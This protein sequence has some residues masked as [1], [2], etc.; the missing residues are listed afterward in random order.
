TTTTYAYYATFAVG[1]CK[2][3]I[4]GIG[5]VWVG[6]Q[7]IYDG[8]S[9]LPG[10]IVAGATGGKFSLY[11][12]T[13]TQL[14]DPSIQA[15]RG[16]ANTPAYRGLAYLVFQDFPLKDYGNSLM[17]AQ[18]KAEVIMDGG[19]THVF[20]SQ[21]TVPS[22][23][24]TG[25]PQD[26]WDVATAG[27]YAYVVNSWSNTLQIF[28]VANPA[29]PVLTSTTPTGT[30][31]AG[32]VAVSG[33]Y[34]YVLDMHPLLRIYD[35]TNP[36]APALVS[37]VTLTANGNEYDIVIAGKYAYIANYPSSY[38]LLYGILIY[39][40]SSPAAPARVGLGGYGITYNRL[41][42][43]GNYLYA[44]TP[45]SLLDIYDVSDPTAPVLMS[46]T[47]ITVNSIASWDV[48][49][50]GNYALVTNNQLGLAIYD[51]TNPAA[52]ALISHIGASPGLLHYMDFHRP[53]V[54]RPVIRAGGWALQLRHRLF[55]D[56]GGA[57][58][59]RWHHHHG[60]HHSGQHCL[61]RVPGEQPN[62]RQRHR[63]YQPD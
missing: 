38:G 19:T 46:S 26:A 57:I 56:P 14:P 33:G 45:S 54:H 31:N 28:N 39:D 59:C 16:I 58:F 50:S 44:V 55:Q 1:L 21:A 32:S 35:V 37:S 4:T 61:C 27:N 60:A 51:V 62:H 6:S 2:G 47:T 3:P 8:S 25:A 41:A 7:L 34:A 17:A 23:P 10:T 24:P 13:D 29:A 48:A 43:S 40:I 22:S 49:V 18:V 36:A 52:P 63:Y 53:F 20:S 15:D 30:T 42:V 11:P 12:G 5:R 9:T